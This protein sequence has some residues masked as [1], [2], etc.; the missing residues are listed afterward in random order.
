MTQALASID[1]RTTTPT[2]AAL[3]W[4]ELLILFVGAPLPFVL[5]YI[6]MRWLMATLLLFGLATL[7]P[8]CGPRA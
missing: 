4:A 3:R 8:P 5:G 6:P 7:G 2:R 1:E